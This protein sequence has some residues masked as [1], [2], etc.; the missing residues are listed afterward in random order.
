MLFR[1]PAGYGR[2][3]LDSVKV[4]AI[5]EHKDA[6]AAERALTLCNSGIIA[7][8]SKQLWSTLHKLT[9]ANAQGE[10]YLTDVV[11]LMNKAG[12]SCALAP[13][14]EADVAGVNDRIQLA[15]IEAVFQRRLRRAAMLDG[16]TLVAPETV[17]FCADTK[18]GCDVVIEPN[19]FF[20]PNVSVGDNV[21]ILAPLPYRRCHNCE[22]CPYRPVCAAASRGRNW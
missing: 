18:I 8:H 6:S 2:L 5:R 22:W 16:A 19:V 20:G 13:C 12:H 4:K 10:L 21:E 11:E 7:V 9:P 1:S 3:L 17:Y 15:S 14:A